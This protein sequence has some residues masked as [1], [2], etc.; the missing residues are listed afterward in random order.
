MLWPIDP[1]STL[2]PATS[3]E[4]F[5]AEAC[6]GM[7]FRVGMGIVNGN[8]IGLRIPIGMGMKTRCPWEWEWERLPWEWGC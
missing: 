7:G 4:T 1:T 3:Y 2:T 8:P 6:V 5:D